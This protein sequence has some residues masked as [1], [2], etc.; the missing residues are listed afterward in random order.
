MLERL[1]AF[2]KADTRVMVLVSL[3][4]QSA[5]ATC[6]HRLQRFDGDAVTFQWKDYKHGA[7]SRAMNDLAAAEVVSAQYVGRVFLTL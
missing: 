2:S 6:N 5:V 1:V 4:Q 3:R 7:A